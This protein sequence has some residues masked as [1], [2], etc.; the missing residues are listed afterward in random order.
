MKDK[1]LL[2]IGTG[3]GIVALFSALNGANVSATDI[4]CDAIKNAEYNFKKHEVKVKTYCGDTYN[5]VPIDIKYDFIFWNHPFNKGDDPDEEVLL[6]AGFDFEYKSLKKYIS[7]AKRHLKPDGRLLLG[8]GNHALITEINNI[9]DRNGYKLKLLE[10][11]EFPIS[12][13]SKI[14]NDYRIYEFIK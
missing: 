14:S 2:E 7:E 11:A 13:G 9:A 1:S 10:K 12:D 5:P 4:N 6:K 3:T 8:T